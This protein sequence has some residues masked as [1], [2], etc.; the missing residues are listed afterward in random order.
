[1]ADSPESTDAA[2][3][4]AVAAAAD[5][6]LLL[7]VD[8]DAAASW[9]T[10]GTS[11]SSAA[12]TTTTTR[13]FHSVKESLSGV[14][15]V[16]V[17]ENRP[18]PAPG[19]AGAWNPVARPLLERGGDDV[20]VLDMACGS[21]SWTREMA[22]MFPKTSFVGAD[23]VSYD[24]DP[25]DPPNI[26][27]VTENVVTGTSFPDNHFD[28]VFQRLLFL[29]VPIGGWSGVIKEL[30]RL[31]KPGGYI[32]LIEYHGGIYGTGPLGAKFDAAWLAT[33][34]ARSV[35][36]EAGTHIRSYVRNAGLEIVNEA[37]VS[38]PIGWNGPI[39]NFGRTNIQTGILAMKSFLA[40]VLKM[41]ESEFEVFFKEVLD[42]C[43]QFKSYYNYSMVV[44]KV[45]K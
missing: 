9:T 14:V 33:F 32:E 43:A 45:D 4:A 17:V 12:A 39:G 44:V 29:G 13:K 3:P 15:V 35:D 31:T 7:S 28:F 21:G 11:G 38:M 24:T 8:A 40:P 10:P 26:R 36:I 22:V 1:M 16:A 2:D 41:T 5:R 42:E 30:V 6:L 19:G 20:R 18:L 37:T 25:R 34:R 27:F 23:I